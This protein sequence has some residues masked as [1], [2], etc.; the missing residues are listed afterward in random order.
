MEEGRKGDVTGKIMQRRFS[1]LSL[2]ESLPRSMLL[3]YIRIES[4]YL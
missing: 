4:L 2:A 3:R 1:K